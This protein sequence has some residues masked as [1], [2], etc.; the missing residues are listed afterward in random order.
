MLIELEKAGGERRALSGSTYSCRLSRFQRSA[1]RER[2]IRLEAPGR[3]DLWLLSSILSI[4]AI[5]SII[6]MLNDIKQ[7]ML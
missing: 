6:I 1:R 2:T 5:G 4:I 3:Q 7:P